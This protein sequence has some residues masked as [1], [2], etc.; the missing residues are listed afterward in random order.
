M[1][2]AEMALTRIFFGRDRW[3]D[4]DSGFEGGLGYAHDV[5]ARTTFSAP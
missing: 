2:P 5:V 3:R 4:S 1:G